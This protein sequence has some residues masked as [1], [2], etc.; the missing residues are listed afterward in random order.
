MQKPQSGGDPFFVNRSYELVPRPPSWDDPLISH[1]LFHLHQD[2]AKPEHRAG[3]RED[4]YEHALILARMASNPVDAA[5]PSSFPLA[6][7]SVMSLGCSSSMPPGGIP[8]KSPADTLSASQSVH[9]GRS[10]DSAPRSSHSPTEAPVVP[11]GQGAL[12]MTQSQPAAPSK[13]SHSTRRAPR[14]TRDSS[15]PTDANPPLPS[16]SSNR[17]SVDLKSVSVEMT[18]PAAALSG[19]FSSSSASPPPPATTAG[20][21]NHLKRIK[22]TESA[23]RS[24]LKKAQKIEGLHTSISHFSKENTQL[25]TRIAT[26]ESEKNA[27]QDREPE[28]KL[29]INELERR[30]ETLRGIIIGKLASRSGPA[31]APAS[32]SSTSLGTLQLLLKV[33]STMEEQQ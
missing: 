11:G 13:G 4:E 15:S 18:G 8:S 5:L 9:S 7:V 12:N 2:P 3:P 22:N 32:K 27:W 26:L 19:R 14:S 24:R 30:L 10:S 6:Q 28:L 21:R 1:D 31:P 23:R 20:D 17:M 16:S 33:E 25:V 29:Q